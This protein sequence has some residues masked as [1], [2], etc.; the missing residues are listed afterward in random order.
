[1]THNGRVTRS[2]MSTSI[3]SV[4]S[5]SAVKFLGKLHNRLALVIRTV[6]NSFGA[7]PK[8]II[9]TSLKDFTTRGFTGQ[10]KA[11]SVEPIRLRENKEKKDCKCILDKHK[12]GLILQIND[13]YKILPLKFCL[14]TLGRHDV[15]W[16]APR[17]KIII[18]C[19]RLF[20]TWLIFIMAD[21]GMYEKNP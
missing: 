18:M 7:S 13:H 2:I 14:M 4:A 15:R 11:W 19:S 1:M 17:G 5:S 6:R 9:R 10:I 12:V 21:K 20:I 3:L 8:E 16:C